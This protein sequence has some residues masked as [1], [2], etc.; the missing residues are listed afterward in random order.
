[1]PALFS[2]AQH[3]ALEEAQRQ[4]HSEDHLFAFLDDLYVVTTKDRAYHAFQTVTQEVANRA[5]VHTHEG[6]LRVWS[7]EG[8]DCPSGFERLPAEVWAGGAEPEDRGIKVLGTPLGHA[9]FV[10]R[11]T[12]RRMEKE[13]AFIKQIVQIEDLQTAWLMLA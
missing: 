4:L 6:K 1:M 3:P 7:R 12:S 8:G 10:A 13:R 11:L 9:A 5:G 2:L